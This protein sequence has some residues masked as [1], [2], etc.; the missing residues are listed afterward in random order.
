MTT[1]TH[2]FIPAQS[3]REA[4]ARFFS[5]TGAAPS[6]AR[7]PKRG[8]L[9]LAKNLDLEVN[10]D[11]TNAVVARDIAEALGVSW[12]EGRHFREG[13]VTLSGL[14][15]LLKGASH[16]LLKLSSSA[17]IPES[18]INE[19]LLAFPDFKPATS[20][21]EVVNRISDLT[22]S[23]P[24]TL[25]PGSKERKS[26]LTN[27]AIRIGQPELANL[28]KHQLA[29]ALCFRFG[30]PWIQTG[31]STGQTLTL[32]GLNLVLV[33]AEKHFNVIS[34]GWA[35]IVDEANALLQV[36]RSDLADYYDGRATVE[37][38][39]NTG[40][41]KWRETEWPGFH[42]EERAIEILTEKFP[43]PAVGGPQ[44]KYNNTVFDYASSRRVWD[45]KAHSVEQIFEPSDERVRSVKG[46]I[47]LNDLEAMHQCICEQG[48]GFIILSGKS[49]YEQDGAFDTWHR[50]FTREGKGPSKTRANSDRRRLRKAG[51][52]P[53]D[54]KALWIPDTETLLA[55]FLAGWISRAPIGRQQARGKQTEGNSRRPK[56]R[57]NLL[58]ASPVVLAEECW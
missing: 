19:V 24:E 51:F 33:G 15:T 21:L 35:N 32:E 34:S 49:H 25:G 4:S 52:T 29:E 22:N 38:M 6:S 3:V 20:K 40:S 1:P 9:A 14:N 27:L 55:G 54:L 44:R 39:R 5:L 45:L 18:S 11:S 10:L 47:L 57:L 30:V 37:A 58:N 46:E 50:E 48:L 8:L 42:F 56:L 17:H 43:T 7:P 36:L 28:T 31:A 12:R 16:E 23:G 2:D 26:V 41:R 13:V 53:V